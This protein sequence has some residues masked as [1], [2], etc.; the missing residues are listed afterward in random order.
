MM[1]PK[2]DEQAIEA[3]LYLTSIPGIKE[4]ILKAAAEPLSQY[5]SKLP[6]TDET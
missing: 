3:T 1:M 2:E 4:S 6:W 5:T